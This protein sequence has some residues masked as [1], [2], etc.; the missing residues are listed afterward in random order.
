MKNDKSPWEIFV[1]SGNRE[2]DAV[3]EDKTWNTAGAKN[4]ADLSTQFRQLKHLLSLIQEEVSEYSYFSKKRISC[5]DNRP[6][7]TAIWHVLAAGATNKGGFWPNGDLAWMRLG[8]F[9]GI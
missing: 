4:E 7:F 2:A 3:R 8:G 9:C 1:W 6:T 5:L